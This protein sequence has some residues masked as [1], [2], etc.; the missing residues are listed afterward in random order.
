MI[1]DLE[2]ILKETVQTRFH[3]WLIYNPASSQ[4]S[5]QQ[6]SIVIENCEVFEFCSDVAVL[7]Y[8]TEWCVTGWTE[9][10]D[11]LTC[12]VLEFLCKKK[13]A[14]SNKTEDELQ[15]LKRLR[16][17]LESLFSCSMYCNETEDVGKYCCKWFPE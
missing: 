15:N 14:N 12:D 9:A 16:A 8:I 10:H 13:D 7:E 17:K 11:A 4:I 5:P 2:K 1:V 6:L 3:D